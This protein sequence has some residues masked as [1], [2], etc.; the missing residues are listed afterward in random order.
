M[1][2]ARIDF[3][4]LLRSVVCGA[5]LLGAVS[6]ASAQVEKRLGLVIGYPTTAGV[7][8]KVNDRF[9]IRGDVG[10]DWGLTE[11]VSSGLSISV[12]GVPVA[13][14][15]STTTF[16]HSMASIGFS[17]LVTV[18]R[19]DQLRLY[20]APRVAWRYMHS[21]FDTEYQSTG[22]ATS[23]RSAF[24]AG[25]SSSDTS[26]GV[27]LDAMFGANYRLGDRFA[28]FGEAGVVYVRPTSTS[29]ADAF[30]SYSFGSLSRVGIAI[31]F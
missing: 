26:N 21:S 11:Q 19:R 7:E 18:T 3:S 6:T 5:L 4:W 28:V 13:S 25:R 12:N 14:S 23:V 27:Q 10:F 15:T 1:F 9:T 2:V 20:L 22:S 16:R 30:N 31:Y 24:D 8:W 17:G 29:S